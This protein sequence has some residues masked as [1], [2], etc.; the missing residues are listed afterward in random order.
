M[1]QAHRGPITDGAKKRQD[2][3]RRKAAANTLAYAAGFATLCF[4]ALA[5]V[6]GIPLALL[7]VGQVVTGGFARFVVNYLVGLLLLAV[8]A[9]MSLLGNRVYE[10]LD[11]KARFIPYVPPV[12]DQIAR[13]PANET[14]LRGSEQPAA[15][16]THLLRAAR[17]GAALSPTELLRAEQ[18]PQET[19]LQQSIDE[20]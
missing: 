13:L 2:Y 11:Q 18:Q 8:L 14:L 6:L 17:H 19:G 10:S 5:V 4:V 3:L 7:L 16:H 15:P 9:G 20:A 1:N 12:Q